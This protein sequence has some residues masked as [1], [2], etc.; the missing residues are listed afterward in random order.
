MKPYYVKRYHPFRILRNAGLLIILLLGS[1]RP[2]YGQETGGEVPPFKERLFYGGSFGLQFGTYTDIE[3]APV[4]GLWVL[5]RVGIAFGPDFQYYKFLSEST[6]IYGGKSYVEVLFLQDLD[7]VIPIGVHLGLFL[8]GEYEA[9]SLESAAFKTP[10]YESKRFV[11]HTF[12]AGGGIRQQVGQR[13]SLNLTFL[14]TLNDAGYNIYGNPEI[15]VS[16]MF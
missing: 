5:P 1:Y 11:T 13:S 6:V 12:L 14:W 7:N 10:P 8:H 16:F 3:V 2:A 15:R 9:L 4:I